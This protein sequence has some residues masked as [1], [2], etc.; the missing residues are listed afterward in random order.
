MN[1][2]TVCI[3]VHPARARS[4]LLKRALDSVWAQTA[5][6]AAVSIAVD[7]RGEGAARTRQRALDAVHTPYVAFL[8]SDDEFLPQH[9]QRLGETIEGTG[10]A[11]VYS[12]F[13]PVGMSDPLGHFGLPFNPHTPHHTTM[14][15]LC[16]TQIAQEIGFAEANPRAKVGNEDWVFLNSFCRIAIE[17]GLVMTHLA[18]RTWRYYYHGQNTSGLPH[19]GD[20]GN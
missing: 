5:L 18:E 14:T 8:D 1:D 15:V 7:E 9:L 12:W 16:D 6:P 17:R 20:A 2:V 19:L 11:F 3:P 13:E 10:A 4:G